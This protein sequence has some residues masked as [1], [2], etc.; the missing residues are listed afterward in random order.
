MQV[1]SPKRSAT[2]SPLRHDAMLM[3]IAREIAALESARRQARRE[4]RAI[5]DLLALRRRELKA[6]AS[7]LAERRPDTPPLRVFGETP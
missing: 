5:D 4:L 1:K 7:S 2:K 6:L 3:R